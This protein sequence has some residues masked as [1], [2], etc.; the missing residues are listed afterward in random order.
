[1]SHRRQFVLTA[2]T[3]LFVV[4]AGGLW[5]Y[6]GDDSPPAVATG[7]HTPPNSISHEDVRS[8]LPRRIDVAP[9]IIPQDQLNAWLEGASVRERPLIEDGVLSFKE[10]ESAVLGTIACLEHSGLTVMH[11]PGYGRAGVGLPGPRLSSRGVYSYVATMTGS[12]DNP[13]TRAAEATSSCKA[14]S[15]QVEFMWAQHTAPS[16]VEKQAMRDQMAKC[17]ID[18]GVDVLQSHPTNADLRA[19]KGRLQS[20]QTYYSC[21]FAVA[22]AFQLDELP[23]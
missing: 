4:F 15:A 17:L 5:L 21:Q 12:A 16:E 11:F 18:A 8:G 23:G 10:Y 20:D 1:M 6:T 22:D 14:G 9:Y 2:L 3:S 7:P 19:V 13:P